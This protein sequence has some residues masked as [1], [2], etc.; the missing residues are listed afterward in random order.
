MAWLFPF[1]GISIVKDNSGEQGSMD[2]E[3]EG[4]TGNYE[5]LKKGLVSGV[6]RASVKCQQPC[7][8]G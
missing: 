1:G 8:Q 5:Y 4:G 2:G 7:Q 6:K 3:E